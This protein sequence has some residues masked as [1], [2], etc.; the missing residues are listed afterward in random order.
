[1]HVDI[2]PFV[3]SPFEAETPR[4]SRSDCSYDQLERRRSDLSLLVGVAGASSRVAERVVDVQQ[5]RNTSGFDDV[6]GTPDDH[7]GNAGF[8]DMACDQTHGLVTHRSKGNEHH[9]IDTV[10]A[11]PFD[12]AIGVFVRAALGVFG[13]YAVEPLGNRT[14]PAIGRKFVQRRKG[15]K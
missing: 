7:G 3:A 12:D 9:R 8:L 13:R 10:F 1:M 6:L 4:R 11:C 14:D 15:K 5:A 2:A